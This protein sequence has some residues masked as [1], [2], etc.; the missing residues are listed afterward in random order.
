MIEE[1]STHVTRGRC[2]E[3]G[4]GSGGK[5]R[6][7]K[8]ETQW[9]K[10]T[11]VVSSS[12]SVLFPPRD[13][14]CLSALD[15]RL[16]H[17]P[18]S[19]RISRTTLPLSYPRLRPE[20]PP[21]LFVFRGDRGPETDV[22]AVKNGRR[23][24]SGTGTFSYPPFP[25]RYPSSQFPGLN[26]TTDALVPGETHFIRPTPTARSTFLLFTTVLSDFGHRPA[27]EP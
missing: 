12:R 1:Y 3:N 2:S 5:K 27:S 9:T 4:K 14:L 16:S 24:A 19:L 13:P 20:S 23:C 17:F 26:S 18:L 15:F 8:R 11:T 10:G 22:R 25:P 7:G 6:R 21:F